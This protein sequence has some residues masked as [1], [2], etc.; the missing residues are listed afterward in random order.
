MEDAND[1]LRLSERICSTTLPKK[2]TTNTMIGANALPN[3]RAICYS[4]IY[5]VKRGKQR[6]Y[7]V[8]L[9]KIVFFQADR[10]AEQ[11]ELLSF[12]LA[13]SIQF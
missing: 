8:Y 5:P 12:T 3:S 2:I 10:N 11:W 9:E 1:S 4:D 6:V 7:S 13:H